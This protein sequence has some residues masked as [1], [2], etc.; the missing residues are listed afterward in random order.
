MPVSMILRS[1]HIADHTHRGP[2]TALAELGLQG[3]RH[4]F[5]PVG[6]KMLTIISHQSSMIKLTRTLLAP[7]IFHH[8][9][10]AF[11][12]PPPSISTLVGCTEKVRK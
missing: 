9:I 2:A 11:E 3:R 5:S 7:L 8:L 6:G 4:E 1:L 12:H 10:G